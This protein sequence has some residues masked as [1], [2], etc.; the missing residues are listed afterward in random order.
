MSQV[1]A[2]LEKNQKIVI[3][4]VKTAVE[5]GPQGRGVGGALSLGH[6]HW[7]T[8]GPEGSSSSIPRGAYTLW[9]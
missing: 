1:Y 6:C 9:G 5:A 8:G 7:G 4:V 3:E 2:F